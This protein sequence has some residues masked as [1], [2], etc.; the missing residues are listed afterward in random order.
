MLK[1]RVQ[2]EKLLE[3]AGLK[4]D[5]EYGREDNF[6]DAE[7][8]NFRPDFVLYLPEG[9]HIIVDSKVSLGDYVESV[10]AEQ[11]EDSQAA[12][13]RHVACVK[14]H[15]RELAAKDYTKLETM[16]S[17][18]FVFMFMPI[19]TAYL[20]AF[21]A[22]PDLFRQAY[23]Q[24][25]AV[26]TPNTLLPILRTVA[27]LWQIQKQ[28]Q[29]TVKLA[30]QA[31]KIHSKL[32]VF[33]TSFGKVEQQLETAMNTYQAAK[34]Q[35]VSGR[36]NLVR[37]VEGFRELGVKTTKALPA[38]LVEE[39]RSDVELLEAADDAGELSDPSSSS[40]T[41]PDAASADPE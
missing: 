29:S 17:P 14:Q 33:A 8:A 22:E 7:G 23:E 10:N 36:G 32:A 34:G 26:V 3:F 13:A 24:K 20:A 35:L 19:E 6:K 39:A 25:I 12:L 1:V 9:R 37:L 31:G 5:R 30:D 38:A 15:I 2:V 11:A 27:S 28:N 40:P 18:D 21:E 41:A 16:K 4:K